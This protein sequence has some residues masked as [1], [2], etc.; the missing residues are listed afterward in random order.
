MNAAFLLLITYAV[1]VIVLQA[2]GFGV[3]K[4]VDYANPTWS[5]LVFLVLFMGAFGLAWPIAVR[6]T[7]PKSVKDTLNNPRHDRRLYGP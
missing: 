2:L 4:L 7:E 5:L 1:V 3:S 6:L